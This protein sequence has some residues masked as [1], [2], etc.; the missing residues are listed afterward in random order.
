MSNAAVERVKAHLGDRVLET[1][2]FRGDDTVRVAPKDWVEA[3]TFLRDD[4]DLDMKL[5]VDLT[6]VDWPER[7]PEPRFDVLLI[8][9]SV[10]KKKQRV[11]LLTRVADG[12]KLPTLSRVWHAADW[13]EREI[14]DMFGIPFEGHPDL[15]RILMYPEFEGYPLRKDYP[16]ERTQPLV[17][18]R[19]APDIQKLPPFGADEGQPWSRID[20]QARLEARDHQVSPA[21]GVQQGERRTLSDSEIAEEQAKAL[22]SEATTSEEA[23]QQ[24]SE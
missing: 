14:W 7:E 9:R 22:P 19:D 6:A 5:F 20:W 2:D 8:V 12:E 1:T 17:P 15:R 4:P 24:R 10:A 18:Y 11:Q 3:A 23:G 21:I 13:A 16:I